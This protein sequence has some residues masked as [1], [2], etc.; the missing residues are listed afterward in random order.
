MRDAT[1]KDQVNKIGWFK[2]PETFVASIN[3]GQDDYVELIHCNRRHFI[4]RG[5]EVEAHYSSK[6]AAMKDLP[7]FVDV[8]IK[9]PLNSTQVV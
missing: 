8:E 4:L 9:S 1:P 6:G 2:S 3:Q 7:R 5:W